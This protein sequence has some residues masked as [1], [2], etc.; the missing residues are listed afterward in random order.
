M[1]E[2]ESEPRRVRTWCQRMIKSRGENTSVIVL[3]RSPGNIESF[4]AEQRTPDDP[5]PRKPAGH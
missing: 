2:K 1:Y 5:T 4:R 3:T